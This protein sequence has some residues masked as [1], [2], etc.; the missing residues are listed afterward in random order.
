M[1]LLVTLSLAP[2]LSD[3]SIDSPARSQSTEPP[4][5]SRLVVQLIRTVS[6]SADPIVPV[7]VVAVTSQVCHGWVGCALTITWYETPGASGGNMKAAV[8]PADGA[9]TDTVLPLVVS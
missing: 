7:P 3:S 2:S 5:A 6:R 9:A 1:P 4:T 8:A